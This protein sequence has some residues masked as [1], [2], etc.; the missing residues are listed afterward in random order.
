MNMRMRSSKFQ[1]NKAYKQKSVLVESLVG[2][3]V[4]KIAED[5]HGC[6][7]ACPFARQLVALLTATSFHVN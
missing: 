2:Y 1:V 7:L 3:L 6:P 5:S 4:L